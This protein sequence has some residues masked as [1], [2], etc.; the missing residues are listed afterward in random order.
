MKSVFKRFT[1]M[2]LAAVMI[3][4]IFGSVP[5]SAA[6]LSYSKNVT[7]YLSAK[8]SGLVD[9][10]IEVKNATAKLVNVKT[11]NSKVGVVATHYSKKQ[12]KATISLRAGSSGTS[13]VTFKV[14]GK[15]KTYTVNVTVKKYTNPVKTLKVTGVS[16]GK[17]LAGKFSSNSSGNVSKLKGNTSNAKLTVT[18]K[19]GWALRKVQVKNYSNKTVVNK[20]VN[21]TKK[22]SYSLGTLTKSSGDW[23][24]WVTLTFKNKKT[25]G[26]QVIE[27]AF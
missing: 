27:F 18:P 16:S 22:T 15:S 2:I 11:S 5:A 4:G 8:K 10:D 24:Y 21:T 3:C 13:K 9:F 7:V 1:A 14:K 17:N 19:S 25:K 12:K 26:E 6:S 20:K 23:N